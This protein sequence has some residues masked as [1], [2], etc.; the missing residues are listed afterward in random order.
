MSLLD[1]WNEQDDGGDAAPGEHEEQVVD[2]H[3]ERVGVRRSTEPEH[4]PLYQ[5]REHQY[6]QERSQEKPERQQHQTDQ[7]ER[8]GEH[9][10]KH[11]KRAADERVL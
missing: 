11:V 10:P 4:K 9:P 1:R 7:Q 5:D 6:R 2:Q 8:S 3:I